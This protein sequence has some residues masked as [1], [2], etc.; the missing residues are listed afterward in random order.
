MA[1]SS[2]IFSTLI[3][4]PFGWTARFFSRPFPLS[5]QV[6]ERTRL[7]R[8]SAPAKLDD[9]RRGFQGKTLL[10]IQSH[11]HRETSLGVAPWSVASSCRTD[12]YQ[13]PYPDHVPSFPQQPE[14]P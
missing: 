7:Y 8:S 5:S 1:G 6:R 13:T 2:L 4:G 14:P 3:D 10:G 11:R 9:R 12:P